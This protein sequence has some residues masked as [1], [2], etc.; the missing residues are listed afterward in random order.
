MD[1]LQ[2][3]YVVAKAFSLFAGGILAIAR[4][5]KEWHSTRHS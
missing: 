4:A 3:A 5:Y 1:I 2:T